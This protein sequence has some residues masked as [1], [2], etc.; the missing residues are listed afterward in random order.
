VSQLG[1]PYDV[2]I[3]D[4]AWLCPRVS[5]VG[6]YSRYCGEPDLAACEACVADLGH[7]LQEEITVGA[8]RARSAR[9]L[10]GAR[11]IVTPSDDTGVRIKRHFGGL[12]PVT[13]PHEDDTAIRPAAKCLDNQYTIRNE[14]N[15][16]LRVCV[17]G[18]I[19]VHK[20]YDVLLACA[21]DAARRNLALEFVVVGNTIDDGRLLAT[22][23]IFVTGGYQPDEAVGLILAQRAALG[24][25]PSIWPETWCLGLGDI[26]RAGL[27]AAAFDIGAPAERIRRSGRGF[28]LPLGLPANSINNALVAAVQA[29][30]HV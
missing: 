7:F 12:S 25:V 24:F 16:R 10:A 11:Q 2:H 18:G 28:L 1:V 27:A 21:R 5:L 14:V 20:G 23:R 8:L 6:A 19:G 3:H 29:T 15:G 30:R 13:A 4:Y 17:V 26:W 22:G 9:F